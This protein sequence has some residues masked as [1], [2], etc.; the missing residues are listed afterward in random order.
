MIPE[1]A[2]NLILQFCKLKEILCFSVVSSTMQ[3]QIRKCKLHQMINMPAEYVATC[4]KTIPFACDIK[5]IS[6]YDYFHLSH[7]R[8]GQ[9][10]SLTK[11][12]LWHPCFVH[13]KFADE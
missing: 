5:I 6:E 8:I 12:D 1:F 2:S 11:L 7:S 4:A 13:V 10:K 3:F 9:Y